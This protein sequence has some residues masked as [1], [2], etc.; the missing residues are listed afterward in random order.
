MCKH[1]NLVL[2]R[3]VTLKSSN[4]RLKID[5]QTLSSNKD[6][7]VRRLAAQ[8]HP[9][10]LKNTLVHL[11]QAT[12]TYAKLNHRCVAEVQSVASQAQH[13]QGFLPI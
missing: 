8:G 1:G 4:F 13:L 5:S 7:K 12:S 2:A 11:Q 9:S 6:I 10:S 3:R